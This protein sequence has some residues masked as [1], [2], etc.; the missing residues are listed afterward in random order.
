MTRA[1]FNAH[2]SP[3]FKELEI[4]KIHDQITLLNCLFVHDYFNGKLPK[5]FDTV[6]H[7][8]KLSTCYHLLLKY[9]FF[10]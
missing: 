9:I 6:I 10:T 1:G 5:S 3:L 8:L 2:T 7:L 4:L